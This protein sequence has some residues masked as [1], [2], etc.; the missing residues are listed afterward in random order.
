MIQVED[1]KELSEINVTPFID[2]M[3]VLL[4][5]FMIV[6][7]LITSSLH[8]ELPK[9]SSQT[10]QDNKKLFIIF[11]NNEGIS[12]NDNKVSLESL[13]SALAKL[14]H[15]NTQE[16]LYFYVDKE[17]KYERLMAIINSIKSLGYEKIALSSQIA[18]KK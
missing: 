18:E 15:N 8:I 14:T 3:L 16:T 12:L 9:S 5:I 10:K 6:A 11:V 17:V 13:P 1:E 7:P 4:I 2:I